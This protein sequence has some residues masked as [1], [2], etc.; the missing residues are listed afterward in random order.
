M[1]TSRGA[2]QPLR[3]E[4]FPRRGQ[5]FRQ[6][7][8]PPLPPA[9]GQG[10]ERPAW[11][12]APRGA[13]RGL[14]VCLRRWRA[15]GAAVAEPPGAAPGTCPGLGGMAGADRGAVPR[16]AALSPLRAARSLLLAAL[17][18]GG[19][20]GWPRGGRDRARAELGEA[21]QAGRSLSAAAA[22]GLN[23]SFF[24]FISFISSPRLYFPF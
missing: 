7:L 13:E 14:G 1:A 11:A 19:K 2:T 6:P 22:C 9:L 18:R 15:S 4:S 16:R 24:L 12:G 23:S 3:S 8:T 21:L 10:F 17:L 5:G 20:R